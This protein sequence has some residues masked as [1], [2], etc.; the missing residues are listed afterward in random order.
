MSKRQPGS[1]SPSRERRAALILLFEQDG[2]PRDELVTILS[3]RGYRVTV[4]DNV[5]DALRT[6][7]I[8]PPDL[9]LVDLDVPDVK[10][11]G[12]GR[13]I[14]VRS[15]CPRIML[16]G[17]TPSEIVA[18][19][20]SG[21]DDYIVKPYRIEVLLARIRAALRRQLV[22]LVND[23]DELLTCGDVTI[24][25]GARSVVFGTDAEPVP[26]GAG[27]F[28]LLVTLGRDISAEWSPT[29]NSQGRCG[30]SPARRIRSRRF[31]SPSAN[32]AAPWVAGHSDPISRQ[33][34]ESG[35]GW[36]RHRPD[37]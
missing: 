34:P 19:L 1:T 25:T 22:P 3:G 35:T 32:C 2:P 6:I 15:G 8:D 4:A 23:V 5:V 26:I 11:I 24:D 31:V 28:V 20:D 33:C 13:H 27:Q 17:D 21:A 14:G 7:D 37:M 12:L 10:G 18:G 29:P 30:A 36:C 9:A 16:G